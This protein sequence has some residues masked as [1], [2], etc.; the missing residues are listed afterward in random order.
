MSWKPATSAG[1]A[2][3]RDAYHH[4]DLREALIQAGLSLLAECGDPAAL[5]LREAARRV[6]VSQA[7]PYAHFHDKRDLL[8]AVAERGFR[9]FTKSM[10]AAAAALPAGNERLSAIGRG[11]VA[12]ARANPALYRLMFGPNLAIDDTAPSLAAA[13]EAA[14]AVLVE[15][16]GGDPQAPQTA[17]S[18]L[19]AWSFAHGLA[20]LLIDGRLPPHFA[21]ENADALIAEALGALRFVTPG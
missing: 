14:F 18:A 6:G 19:A 10:T 7:A 20:L 9:M 5:G 21:R 3:K 1:R 17:A 8:A 12:F 4:G 15:S 2:P 11:Y 16:L 13:G